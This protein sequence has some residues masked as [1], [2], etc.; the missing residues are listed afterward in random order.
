MTRKIKSLSGSLFLVLISTSALAG[1]FNRGSA[2]LD[3][4]FG[5]KATLNTG[6][7]YVSPGR[8][9]SKVTGLKVQGGI[10]VPLTGGTGEISQDFTVPYF[11]I[12]AHFGE[13]TN[14]V[15]S[16]AKPYGAHTINNGDVIY[17]QK[18][19]KLDTNEY[20]FTCSYGMDLSKGN[21]KLI[22]GVFYEELEF[23][24]SRSF[25]EA[26]GVVG[27]ST[28]NV[29]SHDIGY[30]LGIGYEIPEYAL[31]ASLIYRS[32]TEHNVRGTFG[33]TPFA[34]LAV[35][36]GTPAAI[37]GA[38][39]G[40]NMSAT[41]YGNVTMPKNLELKLQSGINKTTLVYGSVK[42]TDWSVL[43]EV[44]LYDSYSNLEFTDVKLYFRD[45][46]T[47]TAGVAKRISEQLALTTSL[48]WDRGVSTGWDT[49]SDT[50]TIAGGVVFD[51]NENLQI[52]AGG[53]AINFTEAQKSKLKSVVDYTASSP[54]EWGYALSLSAV[55]KF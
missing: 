29:S 48:T 39:Y 37:A 53:A 18:E 30:R 50:W 23:S 3:G 17:H 16:Y 4:L 12:G 35:A 52:R 8:S 28:I 2:N 13:N 55:V 27:D 32:E 9:Y 25:T 6:V 1:G 11:S 20:G 42:W 34:T 31:K 24:Q 38:I 47:I 10:V 14:C 46:L 45:G 43:K 41:A 22:G 33:N 40:A 36:G 19:Q 21:L 7:T 51:A 5:D 49:L 15:G 54:N 44:D 26:F